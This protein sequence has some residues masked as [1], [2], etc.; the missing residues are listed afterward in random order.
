MRSLVTVWAASQLGY[1]FTKKPRERPLVRIAHRG[2]AAYAPEN[3]LEACLYGIRLGADYLETDIRQTADGRLVLMH[4]SSLRRT[5]GRSGR[6]E[7]TP[8]D[9]SLPTFDDFLALAR[10][11]NVRVFPEIKGRDI[12]A[13]VVAALH[14]HDMAARAIIPSFSSRSLERVHQLAPQIELCQ[15]LYPWELW[16]R[17]LPKYITIV[18]PMAEALLLNP[19]IV[20]QAQIRG[21]QVWP[22]F[23][24]LENQL[25]IAYLKSLGVDGI[26]ADNPAF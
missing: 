21:L 15:L 23:A 22:W 17:P 11:H 14:A 5:T 18:A 26:I 10:Q 24:A 8:Y 1:H 2:G 12:E 19:W 16:L 3:T 13:P 6:V 7:N 25:T 9:S 4:D 20:R